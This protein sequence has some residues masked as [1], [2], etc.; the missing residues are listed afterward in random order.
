MK[1]DGA[2]EKTAI[3]KSERISHNNSSILQTSCLMAHHECNSNHAVY[4]VKV[5]NHIK[6]KGSE[7]NTLIY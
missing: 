1:K 4:L 5:G 7:K 6:N 2:I 3:K